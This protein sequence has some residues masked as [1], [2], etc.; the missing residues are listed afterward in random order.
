MKLIDYIN[1]LIGEGNLDEALKIARE[2]SSE[3]PEMGSF[4]N[5]INLLCARWNSAKKQNRRGFMD[6]SALSRVHAQISFY[7]PDIMENKV[8][9][10]IKIEISEEAANQDSMNTSTTSFSEANCLKLARKVMRKDK[11]LSKKLL[12]LRKELGEYNDEKVL[13]PNFDSEGIRLEKMKEKFQKY[14]EKATLLLEDSAVTRVKRLQ[15]I[16]GQLEI[17]K[18]EFAEA[19]GLAELQYPNN[20]KIQNIRQSFNQKGTKSSEIFDAWIETLTEI[21]YT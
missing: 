7:L 12:E 2:K 1:E 3:K 10:D 16:L 4:F 18:N 19:L 6:D 5:E 14:T 17:S 15:E 11:G 13:I 21:V 9:D 8:F 20:P